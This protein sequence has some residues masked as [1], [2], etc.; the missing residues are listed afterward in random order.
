MR[1]LRALSAFRRVILG[2]DDARHVLRWSIMKDVLGWGA[3]EK[4]SEPDG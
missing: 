3:L 4:P 2:R 1:W